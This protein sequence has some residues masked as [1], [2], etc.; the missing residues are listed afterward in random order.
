MPSI[1][2]ASVATPHLLIQYV[3]PS[4]VFLCVVQSC[5]NVKRFVFLSRAGPAKAT[6]QASVSASAAAS[7]S[8]S[9]RHDDV[10][11]WETPVETGT[12][13]IGESPP[14]LSTI[15]HSSSLQWRPC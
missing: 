15:F 13:K 6:P 7:A 3:K 10:C 14:K 2:S 5:W 12:N 8:A 1:R 4:F 9:E 11:P